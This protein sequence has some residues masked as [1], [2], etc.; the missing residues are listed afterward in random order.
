MIEVDHGIETRLEE[1]NG[2]RLV[3]RGLFRLH[4]R[5]KFARNLEKNAL[6]LKI[7]SQIVTP[8][9]ND[10]NRDSETQRDFS[11]TTR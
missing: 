8:K 3:L 11:G 1:L 6:F 2:A 4:F 7:L 9:N 10:A 5:R